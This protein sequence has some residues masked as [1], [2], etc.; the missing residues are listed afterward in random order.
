[1]T[2][3]PDISPKHASIG[4]FQAQSKFFREAWQYRI[5]AISVFRH[6]YIFL[7][8]DTLL[9][10]VWIFVNPCIPIFIYIILQYMNIFSSNYNGIPRAVFLTLG[11]ILYYSFSESLNGFTS[12][13]SHNKTFLKSGGSNKTAVICATFLIPLSNFSIRFVLF[14]SVV[15]LNKMTIGPEMLMLPVGFLFLTIL[16]SSIGLVLSVFNLITR[17][18][19]NFVSMIGFYLLFASGVF[20]LIEPTST[21]LTILA[22]SPIYMIIDGVKQFVFFDQYPNGLSLLFGTVPPLVLFSFSIL[23]FYRVEYRINS[24]L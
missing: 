16:G 24:F 5:L 23:A 10:I 17:D 21:F 2:N 9:G 20:A 7:H 18:I 12:F 8:K 14:V 19:A 11:L 4:Y 1:M 22:H 6:N 13:L 15:L 3:D